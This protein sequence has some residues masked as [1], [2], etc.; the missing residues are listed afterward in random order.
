MS[1]LIYRIRTKDGL[2]SSGGTCPRFTKKGKTWTTSGAVTLHLQQLSKQTLLAYNQ[3]GCE[4][5][6]YEVVEKEAAIETIAERL[7]G[8][9]KRKQERIE[10][11]RNRR[12]EMNRRSELA[13]LARLQKKYQNNS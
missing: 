1:N 13:E 10:A 9:Q 7:D 8:I 4:V 5:V 6:A 2:F 3:H 12:E 11:A